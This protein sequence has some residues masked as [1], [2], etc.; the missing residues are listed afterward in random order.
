MTMSELTP[1]LSEVNRLP[2]SEVDNVA[3]KF[4]SP[5]VQIL[6]SKPM[7]EAKIK[8]TVSDGQ[9]YIPVIYNVPQ[10]QAVSVED[11]P[12]GA[13]IELT[14]YEAIRMSNQKLVLIARAYKNIAHKDT[15]IGEPTS[16]EAGDDATPAAAG[17]QQSPAPATAAAP[18]TKPAPAPA[19]PVH[20]PATAG[21]ASQRAILPIEGLSPYHNNWTIRARVA[22]KS[23]VRTWSNQR[24]TGRLFNVTFVDESGEIRATGF[25]QEV[26]KYFDLLAEGQVYYV[27][28]CRVNMAKKQF[29]NVQ[30]DF[31]LMFERDTEI[32]LCT[33]DVKLPAMQYNF[34]ELGKLEKVE[35]QST[36]DVVAVVKNIFDVQTLTSKNTNREYEKRDVML[37]DQSGFEIRATLW[38][39][40]A[41]EFPNTVSPDAVVAFKGI[42]VS[43]F[44]GRS[45]S[46]LQST[47]VVPN[48]DVEQA[49]ALKGWYD[50]QGRTETFNKFDSG[51]SRRDDSRRTLQ[52]VED[53]NLGHSA[54][55]DYFNAKVVI[56]FVGRKGVTYPACTN[57]GCNKKVTEETD[58]SWRCDKCNVTMSAPNYRYM[59][60]LIVADPTT[61]IWTSSF[62]ET[63]RIIFGKPASE[64]A[65]IV[66]AEND[67]NLTLV[68]SYAL[69]DEY[70][71]R[72]QARLDDFN[73]EQKPVRYTLQSVS[74]IDHAAESKRL[75]EQIAAYD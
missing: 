68:S 35:P 41:Q 8:L 23:D 16:L 62:D 20:R 75:L 22:A 1:F 53:D 58:G 42:K 7:S 37:V 38:G 10:G 57:D 9:H 33:E 2:S 70:V 67:P 27:S 24:G 54:K 29:S 3:S 64:V 28:K 60:S 47:T 30:N 12:A 6:R 4:A 17:K 34:V 73:Q 66:D 65:A 61:S 31:E 51:V 46:A 63:A 18:A 52:S 39:K 21:S 14:N 49:H 32:E 40:Q 74:K 15:K 13:I 44:G 45:L 26:D 11:F 48:P 5:H 43:D 25:N 69:F 55:P 56:V 19:A 71:V 72:C 50:A 36:V 59:A